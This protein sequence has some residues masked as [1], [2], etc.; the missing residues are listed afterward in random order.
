MITSIALANSSIML[1]NDN[2]FFVVRTS[3]IYSL[4]N[5]QVYNTIILMLSP[6]YIRSQELGHLIIRHLHPFDLILLEFRNKIK[7]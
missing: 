1:H 5:F 4:R 6:L 2:F 7:L 3:K